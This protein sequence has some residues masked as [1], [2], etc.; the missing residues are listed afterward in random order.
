[1][2]LKGKLIAGYGVMGLL[3]LLYQ[4]I[5]VSGASFGVALG[6]ALVW[7]AVLI[8]GVGAFIGAIILI[9]VLV[10]IYLV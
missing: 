2:T 8:P 3:V 6:K 5:F 10:A 4:W 9:A 7:P 1:M